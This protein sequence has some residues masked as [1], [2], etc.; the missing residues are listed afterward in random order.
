MSDSIVTSIRIKAEIWKEVKKRA[1]E[2]D[3]KIGDFVESS[4]IHEIQRRDR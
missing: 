1:T 4:L 2:L 3:V